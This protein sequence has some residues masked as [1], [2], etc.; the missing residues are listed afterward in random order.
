MTTPSAAAP[1]PPEAADIEAAAH[2]IA[3]HVRV[4]PTITVGLDGAAVVRPD[5]RLPLDAVQ[6]AFMRLVDGRRTLRAIVAEATEDPATTG[7]DAERLA[8]LA[9]TLM[10]LLVNRDFIVLG[11]GS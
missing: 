10:Q 3:P 7:Y 2:R 11:I 1:R 4:T 5:W 9:R 8:A 6:A